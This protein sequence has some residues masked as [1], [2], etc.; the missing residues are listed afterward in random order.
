MKLARVAA[1]TFTLLVP[2]K[3]MSLLG[4]AATFIPM[5]VYFFGRSGSILLS[6]WFY[7]PSLLEL[8]ER[9]K[10]LI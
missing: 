10:T 2:V 9:K 3:I 4:Y 8:E 7:L 1:S 6:L 5:V